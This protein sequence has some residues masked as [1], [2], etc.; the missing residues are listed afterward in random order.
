[1]W[2]PFLSASYINPI[3]QSE[4]K[5]KITMRLDI[6]MTGFI[7]HSEKYY[8]FLYVTPNLRIFWVYVF[9]KLGLRLSAARSLYTLII[10]SVNFVSYTKIPSARKFAC[11]FSFAFVDVWAFTFHGKAAGAICLRQIQTNDWLKI[12]SLVLI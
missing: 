1:M 3:M 5:W 10:Y 4:I 6:L 7:F 2:F 11:Y 12:S 9:L 8:T